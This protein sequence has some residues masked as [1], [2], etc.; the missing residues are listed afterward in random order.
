M[1][2]F[3]SLGSNYNLKFALKALTL[4]NNPDD[5]VRLESYLNQKYQ[6][7]TILLYKGRE[8]IEL[9]LNL[10]GLPKNSAVAING[11]TCYAVY[12]A[13][14]DA[15]YKIEYLDILALA[16]TDRA[17]NSAN[18]TD[19]AT[20]TQLNFSAAT[21]RTKLKQNPTIKILII[22]NT[23]GYACDIEKIAEICR[24]NNIIL[25]EDLAHSVGATY[26]NGKE[27]GSIGDFVVLSFS[28]DKM[29]DAVSGGAL[30][31]RNSKYQNGVPARLQQLPVRQRFR[32]RIYAIATFKIRKTYAI[33]LGKII[34]VFLKKMNL[35]SMPMANGN[36]D[37]S[38][39]GESTLDTAPILHKLPDWHAN[40]AYEQFQNLDENL[41]HRKEI[42]LV[43]AKK[44]NP[45][46]LAQTL[47]AQITKATNLRLPIFIDAAAIGSAKTRSNLINYLKEIGVHISDIWYDAPIAPKKYMPLTAYENFCPQSEKISEQ[48]L[49]LPTHKNISPAQAEKIAEKINEWLG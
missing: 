10:T 5:S 13:V 19:I 12:K 16:N 23:L 43:Y 18:A 46:I 41:K 8:A 17:F 34:H 21:L 35:L 32:D 7:K 28:Q 15:G 33:G 25:I 1:S 40:L 9:A 6:G 37:V 49:N 24:E 26:T 39:R 31:I 47:S 3:N 22:Q 29:I 30:I 4:A 45:K 11:Y 38:G 14:M 44:L 36:Y 27:A 20:E 42:A 48:M 2:I